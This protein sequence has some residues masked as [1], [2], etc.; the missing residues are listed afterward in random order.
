MVNMKTEFLLPSLK[1]SHLAPSQS[2]K[3]ILKM[4]IYSCA[5]HLGQDIMWPSNSLLLRAIG[6][7]AGIT[8]GFLS[9]VLLIRRAS[10]KKCIPS[11]FC[12]SALLQPHLHSQLNTWLQWIGQRQLQDEPRNIY[13]LGLGA[14]YIENWRYITEEDSR[15]QANLTWLN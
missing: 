11:T 7:V 12:L 15:P 9:D 4:M 1:W 8:L 10:L 3:T 5:G 2:K 13:V 14:T 6:W